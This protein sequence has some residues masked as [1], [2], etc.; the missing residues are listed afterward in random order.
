MPSV[1]TI[2]VS[3]TRLR[4]LAAGNDWP[5]ITATPTPDSVPFEPAVPKCATCERFEF[6]DGDTNDDSGMSCPV[7]M[8]DIPQDGSGFCWQHSELRK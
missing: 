6:V 4:G 3:T 7:M 2:H 8:D 5:G 1:K